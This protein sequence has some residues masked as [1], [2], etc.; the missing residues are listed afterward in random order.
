MPRRMASRGEVIDDS[1]PST[2][3]FRDTRPRHAPKMVISISVRPEPIR[4][5]MPRTS[6]F[7]QRTSMS[8]TSFLSAVS[9]RICRS[10]VRPSVR[11]RRNHARPLEKCRRPRGRPSRR[12]PWLLSDL[13][14]CVFRQ[15]S[16]VAQHRDAVA[17]LEN[18]VELMRDVDHADTA[19]SAL[20]ES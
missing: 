20:E 3:I 2:L 6:P 14:H 15:C 10:G 9:S 13:S 5:A 1:C 19:L 18:F 12:S 8:S 7:A 4:P 11:R 16:A 17:H